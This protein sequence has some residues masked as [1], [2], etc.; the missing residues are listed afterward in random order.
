LV[1]TYE[2]RV[3]KVHSAVSVFK[4]HAYSRANTIIAIARR[5]ATTIFGR[6]EVIK[7][8]RAQRPRREGNHESNE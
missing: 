8:Q 3:P 4:E 7:P 1:E 2:E 5:F 6:G